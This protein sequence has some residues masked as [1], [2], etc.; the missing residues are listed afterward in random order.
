MTILTG[1]DTCEKKVKT[2]SSST[3][4]LVA[5]T[6]SSQGQTLN[7]QQRGS[8][9]GQMVV[10]RPRRGAPWAVIGFY[11]P[12]SRE[13]RVTEAEGRGEV[14]GNHQRTAGAAV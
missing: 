8:D 1:Q 2:S 3:R 6:G 10:N 9:G 12:V 11:V 5:P 14:S 7:L 4:S 13:T